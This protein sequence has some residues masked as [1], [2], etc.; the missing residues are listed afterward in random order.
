M[1]VNVKFIAGDLTIDKQIPAQ[2]L[3]WAAFICRIQRRLG[4]SD[5]GEIQ[6]RLHDLHTDKLIERFSQLE[7]NS[8]VR[9]VVISNPK[10]VHDQPVNLRGRQQIAA[11]SE[12][13]R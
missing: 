2:G 11:L 6:I 8:S 3:Q 4:I 13:F 10:Q 7:D 5:S 12:D 1:R 9:A